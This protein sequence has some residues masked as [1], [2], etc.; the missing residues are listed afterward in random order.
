[1]APRRSSP[2][3]ARE[4]GVVFNAA[5]EFSG[6]QRLLRLG[7]ALREK[8]KIKSRLLLSILCTQVEPG[9]DPSF[10]PPEVVLKADA[11]QRVGKSYAM[12][13]RVGVIIIV[14]T[15]VYFSEINSSTRTW[16]FYH[17]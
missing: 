1:M 4:H 13:V 11:P 9:N 8:I 16:K 5:R 17:K 15:Y 12:I 10:Y 6:V 3:A 2:G 14:L 7:K